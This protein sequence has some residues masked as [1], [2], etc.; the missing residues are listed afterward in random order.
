MAGSAYGVGIR[1]ESGPAATGGQPENPRTPDPEAP[2]AGAHAAYAEEAVR[3]AV[4]RRGGA[5]GAGGGRLAAPVREDPGDHGRLGEERDDAHRRATPRTAQRVDLEEPT[6]QRRPATAGFGAR[7][8][9]RRGCQ[10]GLGCQG[11]GRVRDPGPAPDAAG[12]VG[13]LGCTPSGL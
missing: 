4:R 6:Q 5:R 9:D 11:R 12:A 10:T 8:R 7:G 1:S 2:E 3:A 13:I